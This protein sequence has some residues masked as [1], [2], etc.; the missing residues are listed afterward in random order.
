[1]SGRTD[2]RTNC[3]A[4]VQQQLGEMSEKSEMSAADT[5]MLEQSASEG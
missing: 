2:G 4:T 1:M 3:C 5:Q